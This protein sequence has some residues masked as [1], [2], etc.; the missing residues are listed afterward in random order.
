M[1]FDIPI[2][3]VAL[4]LTNYAIV[5]FLGVLMVDHYKSNFNL[6]SF[7][8]IF[9]ML[10]FVSLSIRGLFWTLTIISFSEWTAFTFYTLYWLPSPFQF[11]SFLLLP[12][13]CVKVMYPRQFTDYWGRIRIAYITVVMGLILFQVMWALLSALERQSKTELGCD[14]DEPGE[15]CY[16]TAYSSDAFRAV[17]GLCFISLAII[18][19]AYGYVVFFLDKKTHER[20]LTSSPH[21]LAVINIILFVSF[22][23]RGCYQIEAIFYDDTIH[24]MNIPLQGSSDIN[25]TIF[26]S[27]ELWEYIPTI[28]LVLTLTTKTIGTTSHKLSSSSFKKLQ[29]EVDRIN[30]RINVDY[31]DYDEGF[32][33]I[34]DKNFDFRTPLSR[35]NSS[36]SSS[37]ETV[38]HSFRMDKSSRVKSIFLSERD[39]ESSPILQRSVQTLI[40]L[41]LSFKFLRSLY[42][43]GKLLSVMITHYFIVLKEAIN[44][45]VKIQFG[46]L[47]ETHIPVC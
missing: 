31:P 18:Q 45:T 46:T 22:L 13:F 8:N 33:R 6:L 32:T 15:S 35:E 28:L 7:S 27:F 23:S 37:L 43:T 40:Y 10:S 12:L 42:F 4:V 39:A 11:C 26:I 41:L 9:H 19:G 16:H 30:D 14:T 38:N 17:T 3:K 21:M 2:F 29:S 47:S 24:N 5:A 44:L 20:L 1:I 25:W 36:V 34:M